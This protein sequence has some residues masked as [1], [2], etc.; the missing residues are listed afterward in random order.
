MPGLALSCQVLATAICTQVLHFRTAVC[1]PSPLRTDMNRFP[2]F[3]S[4][5]GV[6]SGFAQTG[7]GPQISVPSGPALINERTLP[8]RNRVDQSA[9]EAFRKSQ[10]CI[11]C[12]EGIEEMHASPNVVLGCTDCHGGDATPGL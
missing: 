7:Y 1:S 8:P 6:V 9:A 11:Q 5:L 3:I 2:L 10:G 12:H 4:I